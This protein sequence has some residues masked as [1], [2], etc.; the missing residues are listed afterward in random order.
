MDKTIKKILNNLETP[1]DS[2]KD[3]EPLYG[4]KELGLCVTCTI[5]NYGCY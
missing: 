2:Y 3:I 1:N 5:K 4:D